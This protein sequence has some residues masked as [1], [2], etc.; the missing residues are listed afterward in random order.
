[1]SGFALYNN[2]RQFVYLLRT[3]CLCLTQLSFFCVAVCLF[4][5]LVGI[6]T[7]IPNHLK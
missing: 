7:T 4:V 3:V 6:A 1:M 5:N 2:N